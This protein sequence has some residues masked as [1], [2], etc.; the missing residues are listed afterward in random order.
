[1]GPKAKLTES[2]L[3]TEHAYLEAVRTLWSTNWP[4]GVPREPHYP[5]GEVPLTEYLRGWARQQPDKPAII[6][7]GTELT[8]RQLDEQSD[9]F[10]ELLA[11]NGVRPG[12]RVALF[13]PN[14]PQFVVCFFGT[15]KLGGVHVPVNPMFREHELLLELNDSGAE[16]I[17]AQDQLM[18][19]VRAIRGRTHIRVAYYTSYADVLPLSPSIPIPESIQHAKRNC[20]DA[21]D[22]LSA[23][24]ATNLDVPRAPPDL[25]A[26]AALNYTG[27]T[28]G[29]PKG[30]VHTQHDMIY[31]AATACT[32]ALQTTPHD[33]SLC[34]YPIF[35]IAGEDIGVIFPLFSGSTCVLLARWDPV[36]F[37][38]AIER[39]C[40]TQTALLVDNAVEIMQHPQLAQFNL[41]S[42]R[43]VW[44]SSF[45]KK[46]SSAYRKRW[47]E[48]AGTDLVEAAWGMT[49]THTCDTFTTGMQENDLDL[50]SQPV[51]VGLPMPGT[52]FKICDFQTASLKDLGEEGELCVRSPSLMKAYWNA[53]EATREAI[54]DGWLHTGDIGMIDE[55]G[56]LHFLGRRREMLKVNGMSVF[57]AEIEALLGQHPD[58][59][60]SGVIGRPD[61]HRGQVPVAFV[62][63][64]KGAIDRVSEAD[65]V[66]WCKAAMAPYKVPEIRFVDVL[67]LTTTGK[68][69]KDQLMKQS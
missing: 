60:G 24:Q 40:V 57:P 48:V 69:R 12:D 9:R 37:M 4:K 32:V 11:A 15:L 68:V 27:G 51:F 55:Q 50:S 65:L 56:Y 30:C 20:G 52:D 34:F 22:L 25:H 33:V 64:A 46:L 3:N 7:Y 47:R 36:S 5:H 49:E 29:M 38:A 66:T 63:L 54:R 8:Y 43:R 21:I 2:E 13:L 42:L 19:L 61:E 41:R 17:I 28:T 16:I 67:P 53:A 10:A 35:W 6:F 62:Q 39:Y 59:V 58:I 18:P 23:L 45:V 1:L 31:T 14:C 44:A 26:I